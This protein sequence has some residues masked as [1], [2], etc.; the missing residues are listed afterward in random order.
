MSWFLGKARP[1]RVGRFR[2]GWFKEFQWV[3]G[4]N[5]RPSLAVWYLVVA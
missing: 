2:I 4:H 1:G 3:L 5:T